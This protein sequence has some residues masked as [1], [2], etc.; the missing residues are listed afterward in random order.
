MSAGATA[1]LLGRG[2][3]DPPELVVLSHPTPSLLA[4]TSCHAGSLLTRTPPWWVPFTDLSPYWTRALLWAATPCRPASI[5]ESTE[6][7]RA[8]CF[9]VSPLSPLLVQ[10]HGG[11]ET[12]SRSAQRG[13]DPTGL[14]HL[15]EAV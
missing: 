15:Q 14:R 2:Q 13:S 6:S 4:R 5:G 9:P 12:A 11:E 10:T 1:A 8:A 7:R 3:G